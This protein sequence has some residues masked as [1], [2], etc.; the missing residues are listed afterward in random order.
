MICDEFCDGNRISFTLPLL[1]LLKFICGFS[2]GVAVAFFWITPADKHLA[3]EVL[4]I[5]TQ[6]LGFVRPIELGK[7][8]NNFDAVA[9]VRNNE[10][11]AELALSI[12]PNKPIFCLSLAQ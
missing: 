11:V 9:V 1:A 8:G 7:L 6:Q 2:Y 3:G 5:F 10:R 4:N 12:N